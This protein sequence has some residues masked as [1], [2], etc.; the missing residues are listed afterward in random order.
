MTQKKVIILISLEDKER[1]DKIKIHPRE[2]YAE[3]IKK[4]LD[5]YGKT[6]QN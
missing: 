4:I 3:V 5:I 2:T 1:L 6:T